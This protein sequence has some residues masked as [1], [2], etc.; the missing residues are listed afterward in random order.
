[1]KG[2]YGVI[3]RYHMVIIDICIMNEEVMQ[4]CVS[5]KRYF[6]LLLP[7]AL[8]QLRGSDLIPPC[9]LGRHLPPLDQ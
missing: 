6:L 4:V 8:E 7:S 2:A 1:M 9:W 5:I 3:C